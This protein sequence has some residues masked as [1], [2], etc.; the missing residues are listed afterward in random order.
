M[1][2][3]RVGNTQAQ[4]RPHKLSVQVEAFTPR[5]SNTLVGFATVIVPEL[6]LRV[7]DVTVHTSHGKRWIGLPGKAWIDRDGT[8]KRGE[9]GKVIYGPVLEFTD[10]AT[11]TAFSDRVIAALLEFA[12]ATFDSEEA[13]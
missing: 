13:A 2:I 3:P 1:D 10:T 7:H 5:H 11:R 6:H 9:N 8:A 12:P 4:A